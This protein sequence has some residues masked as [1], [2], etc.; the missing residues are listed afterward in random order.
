MRNGD[1]T[2]ELN[3]LEALHPR[4]HQPN[5]DTLRLRPRAD[6]SAISPQMGVLVRPRPGSSTGAVVSSA[7][8]CAVPV[9]VV[10]AP[11]SSL[12]D[13]GTRISRC[14]RQI[15]HAPPCRRHRVITDFQQGS[16]IIRP[17]RHDET[18]ERN[19]QTLAARF[20]VG[21]LAGPT[22]K[23]SSLLLLARKLT[24]RRHFAR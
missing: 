5:C 14:H 1:G 21:L 24:V 7:K 18:V 15:R 10:K 2:V 12:R 11:A 4:R 6:R 3:A 22:G 20:Q 13:Q 16:W 19:R 9:C 17:Q 23:K 8:N